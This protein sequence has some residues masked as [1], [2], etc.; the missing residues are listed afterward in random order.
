MGSTGRTGRWDGQDWGGFAPVCTAKHVAFSV[1]S[2]MF[3]HA[4]FLRCTSLPPVL[5]R[6]PREQRSDFA[7]YSEKGEEVSDADIHFPYQLL[8]YPNTTLQA[9]P[10][11]FPDV[12]NKDLDLLDGQLSHL[13]TGQHLYSIYSKDLGDVPKVTFIIFKKAFFPAEV[14]GGTC[15]VITVVSSFRTL[16][17]CLFCHASYMQG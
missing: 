17:L 12:D 5:H 14:A 10:N 15:A 1:L 16:L 7:R 3:T 11:A 6:T 9:G 4:G 8:F 13:E 2:L